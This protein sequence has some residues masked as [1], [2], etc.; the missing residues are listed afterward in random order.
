MYLLLPYLEHLLKKQESLWI[1]GDKQSD[2]VL[3]KKVQ[4]TP[5]NNNTTT[6]PLEHV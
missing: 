1:V 3:D 2:S 5:L 6:S 4:T